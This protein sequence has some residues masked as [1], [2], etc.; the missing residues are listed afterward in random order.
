[1]CQPNG[2][3]RSVILNSLFLLFQ[4]HKLQKFMTVHFSQTSQMLYIMPI[5]SICFE[6]WQSLLM[7]Y[8]RKKS[9]CHSELLLHYITSLVVGQEDI[10]GHIWNQSIQ[11]KLR[12]NRVMDEL[13]TSVHAV[14]HHVEMWHMTVFIFLRTTEETNLL[15][16]VLFEHFHHGR[17]VAL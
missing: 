11:D 14:M 3:F 17:L 4:T 6:Q 8:G 7:E 5:F 10:F 15:F 9:D 13:I 2:C 1:M 16:T 12:T